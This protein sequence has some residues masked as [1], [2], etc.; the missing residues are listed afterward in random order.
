MD[1]TLTTL[2]ANKK[3][4]IFLARLLLE[5]V[6]DQDDDEVEMLFGGLGLLR[7][8]IVLSIFGTFGEETYCQRLL[9]QNH[10]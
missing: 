1:R 4:P 7:L 6:G 2:T 3:A 8:E 5:Y 9:F 10:K